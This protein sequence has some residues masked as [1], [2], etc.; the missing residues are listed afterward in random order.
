M[1]R[2]IEAII[3][4][5]L[6]RWEHERRRVQAGAAAP[7]PGPA[8]QP[9]I[10]LSRQHGGRGEE[11]AA[12]LA[13]RCGYA[14]LD[15]NMID[16][17]SESTGLTRRLMEALDE[18]SRSEVTGWVEA[19]VGGGVFLDESDYVAGLFRTVSSLARLGGVVVVGRGANFIVGPESGIHFRLV[20]PREER[21][22]NLAHG[23]RLSEA[24]AAREIDAVDR[25]RDK[26]IRKAFKRSVDDPL[27]YDLILNE[28]GRPLE[29]LVGLISHVVEEKI[30]RLRATPR[31]D[32]VRR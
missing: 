19:M 29:T 21:I 27:A 26:F 17:I 5:Q 6:R 24:E 10:T 9:I 23:K 18:R 7:E 32:L 12:R 4:R 30:A 11:V 1:P 31:A 25:E 22:K 2:S 28:S 14:L 20:A 13:E 3:D 8:M 16:R 15:R